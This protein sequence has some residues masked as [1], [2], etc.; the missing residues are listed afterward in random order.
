MLLSMNGFITKMHPIT[1]TRGFIQGEEMNQSLTWF[2]FDVLANYKKG[3]IQF[4]SIF[5]VL[6][7]GRPMIEFVMLKDLYDLLRLKNNPKK[8]WINTSGLGIAESMHDVVLENKKTIVQEFGFYT[9]NVNDMTTID[10][11]QWIS[12]HIC[13]NEM[14]VNSNF[15]NHLVLQLITSLPSFYR[16]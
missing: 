11:Q 6:N 3:L 16:I 7:Q 9:L 8:H 5:H 14:N 13:N 2:N 10:N 12:A 15:S 1:R 4:A